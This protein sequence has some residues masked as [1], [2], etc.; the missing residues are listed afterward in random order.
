MSIKGFKLTKAQEMECHYCHWVTTEISI[1]HKIPQA[2]GG[3][4]AMDNLVW[5][6]VYCNLLKSDMDYDEF[7]FRRR[8][9]HRKLEA[10]FEA[11]KGSG[12]HSNATKKYQSRWHAWHNR[13]KVDGFDKT[14]STASS[15]EQR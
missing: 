13:I 15:T 9:K 8:L 11:C 14:L 7:V 10:L 1:D 2:K 4:N 3:G 5:S 6:C 12:P